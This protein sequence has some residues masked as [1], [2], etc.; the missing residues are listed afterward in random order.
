M[1]EQQK[2]VITLI[3]S[4]LDGKAYPLPDNFSMEK[5]VKEALR[6]KIIALVY[7]GALNCGVDKQSEPMKKLF[8][9]LIAVMNVV[10]RQQHAYDK[11]CQHLEENGLDYMPMKGTIIQAYYP[12]KEMR[13]MGDADILIRP[14]QSDKVSAAMLACGYVLDHVTDHHDSWTSSKLEAE[15]HRA[16]LPTYARV[17]YSHF[18]D[19]WKLAKKADDSCYRYDLSA[20]DFYLYTFVHMTKHYRMSGVG[21]KHFVDLWIYKN[22]E[23][24]MDQT[25]ICNALEKMGLLSFYK[26]VMQTVDAWFG[27]GEATDQVKYITEVVFNSGEYGLTST[28][29]ATEILMEAQKEGSAAKARRKRALRVVFPSC[30]VMKQNYKVLDKTPFLLPVF[31]VVRWFRTLF[32]KRSAIKQNLKT[33]DGQRDSQVQARKEALAFVGL[34]FEKQE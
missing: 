29:E 13:S 10:E 24:H 31:W 1:T 9:A 15:I 16:M 14:E 22:A 23:P 12:K 4:A 28:R 19:G 18:E 33:K 21:I 8:P 3:K 26:H 7:Y 5:A 30:A 2:G 17:S 27:D 34:D 20:E 6:H 25:Y 11:L 32:F